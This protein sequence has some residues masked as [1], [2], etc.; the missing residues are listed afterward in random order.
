M[1]LPF[2]IFVAFRY[3]REGRFQTGLVVGASAVGVT[4][5]VFLSALISGLEVRIIE[6][7]L[8][9]QAHIVA[10]P[11]EKIP[12]ALGNVLESAQAT[13]VLR[14][15]PSR[16]RVQTIDNWQNIAASLR[17]L[18]DLTVSPTATGP[19]VAVKGTRTKAITLRGVEPAAFSS[20]FHVDEKLT[21][22]K[23][24][25]TGR[26]ALIGAELAKDLGLSVGDRLRVEATESRSDVYTVRG[27]FDLGNKEV[28]QRWVLVS[29]RSAQNMFGLAAG[30]TSFDLTIADIFDARA[31]AQRVAART[32]LLSESWM[33]TNA[34]LLSAL[35]SQRSSKN[36]INF[37]ITVA[38]ALSIAS[39]LVVSVVQ[40]SREIGIL[41]ATGTSQAQILRIFLLQGLMVG[42]VGAVIGCALG[43]GMA[44]IFTQVLRNADGTPL[45]PMKVDAA[46]LLSGFSLSSGV[47][48]LAAAL[49][50]YRASRLA[51][52][53]AIRH[54]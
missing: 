12:R 53:E 4:V 44:H 30:I 23:Y 34:Q 10:R 29:L 52:A 2:D 18:D 33:D 16:E 36:T 5:L 25:I 42:A 1:S 21:E 9:G 6:R 27:V 49:P 43:T 54:V 40:K 28:N 46:L 20:V 39:V 51:P 24:E 11:E 13:Q 26:D 50:A 47:G 17:S 37:F 22:G 35:N 3:L 32:G 41:R 31:V 38:V 45:L 14:V 8:G 19:A 7:T 15:E 48:V